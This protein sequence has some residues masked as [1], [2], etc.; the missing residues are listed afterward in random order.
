MKKIAP[1]ILS[2]DFSRLGEEIRAVEAGGAD[3]IHVDVMDGHF[4]PNITIGPLVVEAVRKITHLPLDVH[5]MISNP[6]M[7]IPEFAKAGA[8][9]IVIHAEATV[10]LHR[11][12]QLIKSFGKKA[13]VAL[14][15]GTSL[16]TL[17]YVLRD[18]D[19][20]L[21]MTVNPGFGGQ[22]FIEAC[23]P[24]IQ[25]LRGMLDRLG[26]ETELEVDGGVKTDNIDRISHAGADVF[27]AG[28]AVFGSPEYAGTI[29]ELKRRA[30]EPIL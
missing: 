16:S 22:S 3:Y 15:P 17:E 1:S 10:H 19:L 26:L 4:V 7:Y 9:I 8:D 30:Q 12:L 24:K 23:I 28:S 25:S 21:L 13:G 27:V 11:A 18:L 2:A 5:L 20:V 14:N 29:S 6:E